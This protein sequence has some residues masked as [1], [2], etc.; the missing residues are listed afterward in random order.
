MRFHTC[1]RAGYEGKLA[2]IL[3]CVQALQG[4]D[5]LTTLPCIHTTYLQAVQVITHI[6]AIKD[7]SSIREVRVSM[8]SSIHV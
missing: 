7:K 3:M 2:L 5:H 6:S 4:A 1:V 8:E